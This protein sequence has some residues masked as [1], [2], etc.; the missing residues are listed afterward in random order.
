MWKEENVA[1]FN[2]YLLY[3]C[4]PG[5]KKKSIKSQIRWAKTC[6]MIG[7][8]QDDKNNAELQIKWTKTT[9][10]TFEETIRRG[11][12]RSIEAKLETVHDDDD[13][14]DDDDDD[15]DDDD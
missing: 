12:Y 8:Q 6:N 15:D 2:L 4:L 14:G 9:G 3:L 7:Q 13:D 5:K 11:R 10:K 1:S